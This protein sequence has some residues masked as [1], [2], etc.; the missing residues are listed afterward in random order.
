MKFQFLNRKWHTLTDNF[1]ENGRFHSQINLFTYKTNI[2][3]YAAFLQFLGSKI[4]VHRFKIVVVQSRDKRS[5]ATGS[6][7]STEWFLSDLCTV[8]LGSS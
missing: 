2:A 3:L 6:Q 4:N 7:V 8:R 1:S 5:E